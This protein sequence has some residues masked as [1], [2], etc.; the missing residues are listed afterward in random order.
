MHNRN[1]SMLCGKCKKINYSFVVAGLNGYM[2][3]NLYANIQYML[4]NT[5]AGY[6]FAQ[7]SSTLALCSN[8]DFLVFINIPGTHKI[9]KVIFVLASPVTPYTPMRVNTLTCRALGFRIGI[10]KSISTPSN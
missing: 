7:Y 1:Y 5:R 2:T 6:F 8:F 10:F 3:K 9:I 4:R